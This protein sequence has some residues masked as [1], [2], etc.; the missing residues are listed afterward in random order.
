MV[1][2]K[3]VE[4]MCIRTELCYGSYVGVMSFFIKFKLV[5][6]FRNM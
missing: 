2:N 6:A 5:K 3:L 4:N 1:Q